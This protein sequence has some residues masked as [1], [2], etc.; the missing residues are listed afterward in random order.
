MSRKPF[1]YN[2][3]RSERQRAKVSLHCLAQEKSGKR[4]SDFRPL[5]RCEIFLECSRMFH[6]HLVWCN[7][8][9]SAWISLADISW[10]SGYH[11]LIQYTG[12]DR[13][14]YIGTIVIDN[15]SKQHG[16]KHKKD[17]CFW[18]FGFLSFYHYTGCLT[19]N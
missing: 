2:W 5:L 15:A 1:L 9:A 11:W 13:I 14:R 6:A 19:E 8:A 18:I 12:R 3:H 16:Y 4:F 17:V 10:Q 7:E